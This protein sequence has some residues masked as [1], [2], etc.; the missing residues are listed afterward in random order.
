MNVQ[1]VIHA[2][3]NL[4]ANSHGFDM[5]SISQLS[6]LKKAFKK[7]WDMVGIREGLGTYSVEGKKHYRK[8]FHGT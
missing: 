6:R 8:I 1:A 7:E 3:D 5:K 4:I 2:V